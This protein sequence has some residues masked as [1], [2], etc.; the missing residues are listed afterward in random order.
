MNMAKL[1]QLSNRSTDLLKENAV[2]EM[3]EHM[4]ELH[5]VLTA[6]AHL[7]TYHAEHM[8]NSRPISNN[9]PFG[10]ADVLN[11]EAMRIS[12]LQYKA[13]YGHDVTAG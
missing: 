5:G 10:I 3:S 4:N 11:R 13:V 2:R 6:C 12:R 7:L 8:N 9:L 1:T